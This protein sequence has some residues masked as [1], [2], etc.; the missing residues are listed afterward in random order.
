MI[1]RFAIHVVALLVVFYFVWSIH[2]DVIGAAII[3]AVILA[4]VNAV[5]RPILLILTLPVTVLTLGLFIIVLNAL[6]F[7][8]SFGIL[9]GLGFH[10]TVSFGRII[11]GWLIYVVIS[12]VLTRLL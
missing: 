12:T 4:L 5:L 7:A 1:I 9:S 3:M 11:L 10:F 2:Q 8:L 6:L